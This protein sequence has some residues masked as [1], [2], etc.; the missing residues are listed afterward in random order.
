MADVKTGNDCSKVLDER[1]LDI[2]LERERMLV[3]V[4]K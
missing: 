1:A 3:E 4:C 2:K